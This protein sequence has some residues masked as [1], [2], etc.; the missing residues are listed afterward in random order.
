MSRP[1]LS[2]ELRIC[3]VAAI[4]FAPAVVGA[5]DSVVTQNGLATAMAPVTLRD[6][7]PQPQSAYRR[8]HEERER[9]FDRQYKTTLAAST[10]LPPAM[11]P[12]MAAPPVGPR[13]QSTYTLDSFTYPSDA[14]GAVG[15]RHLLGVSNQ[16]YVISDRTGQRLWQDF[17][18]GFW[19]DPNVADGGSEYDARAAYDPVADRWVIV[20]LYDRDS[21]DS[22]ILVA[23]TA[24]G[25]PTQTWKRFRIPV[26]GSTPTFFDFT[27]LALT[28]DA[29]VIT[30]TL[31][32]EVNFMQ[33]AD[34]F[35]IQK[36]D[37][38]SALPSLPFT[39]TRMFGLYELT[40]ISV[41]GNDDPSIRFLVDD[42]ENL[43]V[44]AMQN[45]SP[46]VAA[47]LP[48]SAFLGSTWGPYGYGYTQIGQQLGSNSGIDVGWPM[49][50]YAVERGGVIWIVESIIHDGRS[51]ILWCRLNLP[52]SS[53]TVVEQG[54]IDDPKG[55]MLFAY[56]SIDVNA[57][58]AA[59][60]GYSTLS[61]DQFPSSGYSYIDPSLHLS[62]MGLLKRGEVAYG[63]FRWGDYSMTV[64]DPINDTDFWTLQTSS[65][66][67]GHLPEDPHNALW[68]TYWGK[69]TPS[70]TLLRHHS[71]TH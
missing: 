28:R 57:A 69:I 10:A 55:R 11:V 14:N 60:I 18:S 71:A 19:H 27:R 16:N 32:G 33:A 41:H 12:A 61:A 68:A 54:L 44:Y 50:H 42:Y 15:P 29:I 40:P 1:F 36:S 45:G 46:V 53:S 20:S 22:T 52:L 43:I 25:D 47:R 67:S 6:L 51:S 48:F 66:A 56:P 7:P 64:V 38:Y 2:L 58:G 8:N 26:G 49:V 39:R 23:I 63:W 30:A 34:V 5:T 4:A 65:T 70:N 37:A 3:V 35:I 24:T 31:F 13:L 21:L 17:N 9:V 59:L 62:Q